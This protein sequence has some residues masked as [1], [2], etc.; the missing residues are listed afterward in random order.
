MT[1]PWVAQDHVQLQLGLYAMGALSFVEAG[2]VEKHLDGCADCRTECAEVSEV[3][4]FL[5]FLSQEDVRSLAEEVRAQKSRDRAPF[6]GA[7][8]AP[9]GT[10][11]PPSRARRTAARPPTCRIL[12]CPASGFSL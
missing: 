2:A 1:Q 3:L 9:A 6:D 10:P 11:P 8:R 7:G 4:P 12:R 5:S